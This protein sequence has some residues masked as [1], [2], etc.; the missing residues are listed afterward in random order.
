MNKAN[1]MIALTSFCLLCA[2]TKKLKSLYS[3]RTYMAPYYNNYHVR[4][5]FRLS[6][7]INDTSSIIQNIATSTSVYELF[8]IF[9]SRRKKSAVSIVLTYSYTLTHT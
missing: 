5:I 4:T 8:M 1:H 6:L 9:C 3:L 7:L 2:D